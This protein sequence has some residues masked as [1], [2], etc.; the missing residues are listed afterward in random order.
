MSSLVVRDI[1][2]DFSDDVPFLWQPSNPPFSY[3]LNALS[4]FFVGFERYI[5]KAL[6]DATPR[7]TSQ[8]VREEARLFLEQEAKH[9]VAHKGHI[10]AMIRGY[11]GLAETFRKTN[12][13]WDQ[14]YRLESTDFHLAYIANLESTFTPTLRFVIEHRES[15]FSAG[16]ARISSLFLW[17]AIEEIEHRSSAHLIY[18]DVVGNRFYRLSK[19]PS[20]ARHIRGFFQLI[21][22]EFRACIPREEFDD[23]H[24]PPQQALSHIPARERLALNLRLLACLLPGHDPANEALPAWFDEWMLAE[25]TGKDMSTFYGHVK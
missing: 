13:H 7:I 6:R 4:F 10:E 14:L 24:H 16:D 17:H 23:A 20:L 19:I 25:R 12:G 5:I 1:S 3:G 21:W 8:E 11:P 22:E 2:F 15:L 18:R 9:S